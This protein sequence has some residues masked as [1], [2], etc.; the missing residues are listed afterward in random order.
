[1]SGAYS[2]MFLSEKGHQISLLFQAQF[3]P[4]ELILS[5][6]SSK[7]DSRGVRGHA[8]PEIF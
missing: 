1:M 4:P 5:N 6:L 3:F 2:E 8:P 7:N